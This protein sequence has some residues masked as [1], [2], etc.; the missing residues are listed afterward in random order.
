[1]PLS[2]AARPGRGTLKAQWEQ[3]FTDREMTTEWQR[4]RAQPDPAGRNIFLPGD[5]CAYTRPTSSGEETADQSS[6]S[7]VFLASDINLFSSPTALPWRLVI[8]E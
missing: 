8:L 6:L 7:W 4:L 2:H 3:S 5:A 1:M